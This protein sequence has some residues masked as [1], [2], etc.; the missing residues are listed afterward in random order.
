MFNYKRKKKKKFSRLCFLRGNAVGVPTLTRK[1]EERKFKKTKKN[2]KILFTRS[3]LA[4]VEFYAPICK[5][6]AFES[7]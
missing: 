7:P 3:Q 2:V 6:I 4:M 1:D 5:S